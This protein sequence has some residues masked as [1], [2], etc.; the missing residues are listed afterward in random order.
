MKEKQVEKPFYVEC[1]ECKRKIKRY[2]TFDKADRAWCVTFVFTTCCS[3][4]EK[5]KPICWRCLMPHLNLHMIGG[6][7][8]EKYMTERFFEASYLEKIIK[9]SEKYQRAQQERSSVA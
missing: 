2:A 5:V 7:A 9:R 1:C 6:T 4:D 8:T 3:K